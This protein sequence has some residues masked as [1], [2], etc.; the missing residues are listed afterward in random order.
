MRLTR[1]T[2]F[3]LRV[4]I[5]AGANPERAVTISEIAEA[6]GIPRNHLM[7]VV[8]HLATTGFLST[9]RGNG[10]GIRLARS[11]DLI[12]I[13]A[14]IRKTEGDMD[15]VECFNETEI[16]TCALF[17]SCLLRNGLIQA[18]ESFLATLDK[19]SLADCLPPSPPATRSGLVRVSVPNTGGRP[20]P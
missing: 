2:D 17:P 16:T 18:K 7:K 12:S 10:G 6:H 11:P 20:L 19:I 4:L 3:S 15:I 14:V 13:G 5:H 9:T 8:N 1:F